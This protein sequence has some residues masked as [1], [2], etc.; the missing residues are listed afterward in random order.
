MFSQNTRGVDEEIDK[1]AFNNRRFG[2]QQ[3]A[4]NTAQTVFVY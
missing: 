2:R 3:R 4:M 1:T